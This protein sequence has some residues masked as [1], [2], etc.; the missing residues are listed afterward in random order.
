MLTAMPGRAAGLF[1]LRPDSLVTL[2]DV[3]SENGSWLAETHKGQRVVLR[4][5]HA[6]ATPEDLAYEHAVLRR[7]AGAGWVVPEPVS[8]LIGDEGLW[9]CLT[10][11]VPGEPVRNEAAAQRS[12]RGADLARLHLALRGFGG[13]AGQRPGWRAQQQGVTVHTGLDWDACLRALS[14]ASPRLG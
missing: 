10:R 1:R 3:P 9:Y 13:R 7:L 4:R 12:R 6:G 8:E 11:Y 14:D 5:Y 2:K